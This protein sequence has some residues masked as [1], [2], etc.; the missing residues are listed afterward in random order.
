M[1]T[2]TSKDLKEKVPQKK[3]SLS[4]GPST[5]KE[6]VI[7][8]YKSK[9]PTEKVSIDENSGLEELFHTPRVSKEKVRYETS[10]SKASVFSMA[11]IFKKVKVQPKG[12]V[13]D[14]TIL[15]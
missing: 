9:V 2:P 13:E 10:S 11:N 14:D 5:S 4:L 15:V 6:Q 1:L 12:S 8:T 7:A 3:T